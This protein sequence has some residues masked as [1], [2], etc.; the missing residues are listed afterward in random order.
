MGRGALLKWGRL[1]LILVVTSACLAVIFLKEVKLGLDLRGGV[2]LLLRAKF[3]VVEE[4]ENRKLSQKEKDDML[5][6]VVTILDNRVNQLGLV[7]PVITKAGSDRVLVELPGTIDPEQAKNLVG[8]TAL[9]EFK[10]VIKAERPGE[11]SP[12]AFQEV[13]S[14]RE[15]NVEELKEQCQEYLLEAD[16][17]L[18]GAA[19]ADASVQVTQPGTRGRAAGRLY[20]QMDFNPEGAKDFAAVINKLNVD[21]R[22]A[23]ILDN[24]VYSAPSITKSIKEAARTQRSLD[25]AI[26]EGQFTMEE[27]RLLAVVLRAG[28]LP[29]PLEIIQNVTVGPSLGRDSIDKGLRAAIVGLAL[30]VIFM[31]VYY[32]FSGTIATLVLGLNLVLLMGVLIFMDATLTLPGIAGIILMIGMGVDSNVLIFERV[33]EEL[34][35]DKS[36]RAAIEA[37][38]NRAWRTVFDSHVTTLITAIILLTFG[39]GPIKGFGITLSAGIIINL[40]SVLVGTKLAFDQ[41]KERNLQR[42]SI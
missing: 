2:M 4:G 17:L 3:E 35:A 13:L 6:E 1:A 12:A 11:L 24:V 7:E 32:K 37:G 22:I 23:I 18:T 34:R 39:T 16:T 21:D 38:Y 19:L 26:I 30:V 25:S 9:L 31:L 29:A 28:K 27:A 5:D 40:F 33:R 8:Q 36:V 20:I 15:C 14:G 42:L 10:K 41:I